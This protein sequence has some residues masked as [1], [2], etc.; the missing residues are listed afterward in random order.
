[1]SE[2]I[3]T[4][5][6]DNKIFIMNCASFVLREVVPNLG[7]REAEGFQLLFQQEWGGRAER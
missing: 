3:K 5:E 4:T 2:Q 7:G 1:M 6:K